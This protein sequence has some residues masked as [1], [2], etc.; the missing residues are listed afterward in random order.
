[1]KAKEIRIITLLVVDIFF[2]LLEAIVGY[3]VHSLAL[4]AD[5]FHMLNDIIS[6][7]IALWAVKVKNSK[8]ADGKYTYGWQ[9][10]EIIGALVNAVFLLALCFTIVIEAIQRFF[11]PPEISNPQLILMVGF[12]GLLSNGLGLVLF[13]EH[14]H[15]HGHSHGSGSSNQS[16]SHSHASGSSDVHDEESNIRSGS[17][18]EN[19]RSS[20]DISEYLPDTVVARHDERSNLL[21]GNKKDVPRKK[22]KSMNMEGVFLHV[23]GDALGNVGVIITAIFIWKTDYSWRFYS[24]PV[25][26]LFI[27]LI[28]FSSA[29]PLCRKSCKILLQA[30]PQNLDSNVIVEEITL[31]PSIK[32]IHDFH[33]WNLDEDFLVAS[34]HIELNEQPESNIHDSKGD[35]KI[36]KNAFVETVAQVREILFRSGISSVTIQ[37][38]FGNKRVNSVYGVN[39][40][41]SCK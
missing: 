22:L 31:L 39:K 15:S 38:E 12:F 28:I 5:S 25:V 9:R 26:S 30:T 2:F 4:I 19:N 14:G 7:F 34:L 29:L 41:P 11:A 32:A 35:G 24:D 10:A 36:D 33:V 13:H 37:P 17:Y 21:S 16:H 3:T 40:T 18:T 20:T 27:T 8:P 23:L 1:M 6:L